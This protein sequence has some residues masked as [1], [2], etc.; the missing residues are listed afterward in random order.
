MKK[1]L[2]IC[3][4]LLVMLTIVQVIYYKVNPKKTDISST[5]SLNE[6]D[7]GLEEEKTKLY[8]LGM[9]ELYN[10][11]NPKISFRD[12]QSEFYNFIIIDIPNIYQSIKGK[13]IEEIEQ[14]Y[15]QNIEQI[16]KMNITN[17]EEFVMIAYQINNIVDENDST[18]LYE[19][20]VDTDSISKSEDGLI[21]FKVNLEYDN[22]KKIQIL[23]TIS[24]VNDSIKISSQNGLDEMFEKYTGKVSK[25]DALK[26]IESFISNI[27]EY[28]INSTLKTEN[29]RRQYFDLNKEDLEKIGITSQDDYVNVAILI[30]RMKWK[31][32]DLQ[33]ERYEILP[34][35]VVTEGDYL[36]SEL[37]IY[38]ENDSILDLKI[39]ISNVENVMPD[40]K[41]SSYITD[42]N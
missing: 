37:I 18:K 22:E 35:K 9:T 40:I 26:K 11:Y 2:I 32:A 24:E 12:L 14:Y 25:V 38:Y 21:S 29:E 28:R 17:K 23:Y 39:S 7:E 3:V 27:K 36:S 4:V 30:N 42:F 8:I 6:F 19:Y 34:E 13:N 1:L 33:Y 16:N 5:S 15:D 20:N 41:I 10:N 31:G